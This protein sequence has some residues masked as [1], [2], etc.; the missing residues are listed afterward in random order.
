M[1]IRNSKLEVYKI[2]RVGLEEELT[3]FN[4][5]FKATRINVSKTTTTFRRQQ[6]QFPLKCFNGS[7]SS[8]C[9]KDYY[10][11]KYEQ[12]QHSSAAST[13]PEHFKWIREDLKAWKKTGITR[14]MLERG[15]NISYIRLVVV[16]GKA[17]LEKYANSYQTRD[18]FTIWGF[19]QLLRLYPG[20]IPDL[21][22]LFET[23][24]KTVVDKDHF[25]GP[26]PPIFH[27]CGQKDA[28]DIVFPDWSFWGW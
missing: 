1:V 23:G 27:Y 6:T 13:C 4:F 9:P 25:Q 17:Y 18:V 10:P 16:K 15:K 12:D 21:E 3:S 20:N 28:Y 7:M 14:E 19:V 5:V 26:P 22:L 11:T 24:D 8:T 2:V